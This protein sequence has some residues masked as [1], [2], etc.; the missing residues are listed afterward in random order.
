[1]DRLVLPSEAFEE[2]P[3]LDRDFQVCDQTGRRTRMDSGIPAWI[4]VACIPLPA[5]RLPPIPTVPPQ[6][7][8]LDLSL[9]AVV[10]APL[11]EK[12][13]AAQHRIRRHGV[14]QLDQ[15]PQLLADRKLLLRETGP[16]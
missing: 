2:L 10:S 15:P 5:I 7:L 1:M 9:G 14:H 3:P 16:A 4:L 6:R 8:A 12:L 13:E 11:A